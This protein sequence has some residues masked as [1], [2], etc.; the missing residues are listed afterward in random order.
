MLLQLNNESKVK[1]VEK[2]IVRE[3]TQYYAQHSHGIPM[4]ALSAKYAKSCMDIGGFQDVMEALRMSGSIRVDY[5]EHGARTVSPNNAPQ[6]K[7]SID[8]SWL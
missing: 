3:V 8:Y 1:I 2:H 7:N 4:Q 6:S 5:A